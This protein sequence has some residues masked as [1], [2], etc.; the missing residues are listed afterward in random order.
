MTDV[1]VAKLAELSRIAVSEEELAQ[2]EKEIPE[3]L[4]FVEQIAEAGGEPAK[5]VGGHYNI[6]REDGESHE[7]GEYSD[8]L[9]DAMPQKTEDGYLKVRKIISH[10]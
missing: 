3:I 5:E 7:S 6:F 2:L 4:H 8:T 1:D 10:D 9:V